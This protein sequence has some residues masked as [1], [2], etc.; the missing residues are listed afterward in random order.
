VE[1]P[2]VPVDPK[3][4]PPKVEG[5]SAFAIDAFLLTT[6]AFT[7]RG[8]LKPGEK[9]NRTEEGWF[10]FE[11]DDRIAPDALLD[12]RILNEPTAGSYQV[13]LRLDAR[14]VQ[15]FTFRITR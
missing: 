12:L 2:L 13:T 10:P 14:P 8:K 1:G 4:I 9:Y 7:A 6:E 11:P 3:S 15:S 5:A